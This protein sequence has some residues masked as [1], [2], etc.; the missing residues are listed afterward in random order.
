[1]AD[2]KM[3]KNRKC[4]G[5]VKDN[6]ENFVINSDEAK[7]VKLI[8]ECFLAG[9]SLGEISKKLADKGI[10]SPSGKETWSRKVLSS[11]LANEKYYLYGIISKENFLAVAEIK[12]GT[13]TAPKEEVLHEELQEKTEKNISE[14]I[15]NAAELCYTIVKEIVSLTRV[16]FAKLLR[17][18]YK[19]FLLYNRKL[20]QRYIRGSES[21][22]TFLKNTRLTF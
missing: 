14:T 1:M 20:S 2:F 18:N 22:I 19:L 13:K 10:L 5:F 15:D 12:S 21:P 16:K 4:Y 3:Y 7:N 11:M 9:M 17:I 6:S 8:F